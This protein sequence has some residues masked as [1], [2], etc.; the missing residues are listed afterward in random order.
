MS[1]S[2]GA[3]SIIELMK[4][5]GFID[6]IDFLKIDIEGTEKI[7]FDDIHSSIWIDKCKLVSCELHDRFVEGCS[8]SFHTAFS[9]KPFSL[10]K[11]GEFE[12][13]LRNS[14]YDN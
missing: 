1:S 11:H 8:N 3:Y 10:K 2:I 14:I 13:Y 5:A 9:N 6:T 4:K 12:Y 7:L